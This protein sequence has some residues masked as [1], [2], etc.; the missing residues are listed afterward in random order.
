MSKSRVLPSWPALDLGGAAL[1][2]ELVYERGVW[3]K[4][5][6]ARTDYRW[7]AAS[8]GF[9]P[10]RERLEQRFQLGYEDEPRKCSAWRALAGRHYALSLYPSKATDDDGRSGFLEKQL[11]EWRNDAGLP[12]ALGAL[13]LLPRS[14]TWSDSIWWGRR[15]EPRLAQDPDFVLPIPEDDLPPAPLTTESIENAI[16]A[17]V[18]AWRQAGEQ[19]LADFYA[20]LLAGQ[21]GATL[22]GLDGPPNAQALA[23]LLLPL[24]REVADGLSLAGWLPATAAN[25][26]LAENW[27]GVG[28][29]AERKVAPAGPAPG[30]EHQRRAE[31]LARAL[32][33]NDPRPLAA[34]PRPSALAVPVA[35]AG[36]DSLHISLWGPSSAGKTVL[37]AQLYLFA[38]NDDDDWEIFP[39]EGSLEFIWKMR[40][41]MRESNR[42]PQ[43]TAVGKPATVVYAFKNAQTGAVASMRVEDRAGRTFEELD[44]EAQKTLR[45]AK[46]LVLLVD[47]VLSEAK[48]ESQISKTLEEVHVRSGRGVRKDD[49]P[50]A[51]C[52]SKADLL[53]ETARDAERAHREPDAFVRERVNPVLVKELRRRCDNFK[54]FPVS[55]AGVH[56]RFGVIEPA[57]F[58]DENL[59]PRIG[60]DG[61]PFNLMPPFAWVLDQV[62]GAAA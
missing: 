11:L 47:P 43:A 24:P 36:E 20:S 29:A 53:I 12:A 51:V 45:E 1:P 58:F 50:I 49:R 25:E 4:V 18:A 38:G 5:H 7:I 32:L 17:G 54:L 21:R 52:V 44:E 56:R 10:R 37:L 39:A 62:M 60:R 26:A 48:L 33:E 35:A 23:A 46:G 27:N 9:T 61:V 57:V 59:K 6:G 42:F 30:G 2:G 8:A 19:A 16:D 28:G 15:G 31:R 14:A 34:A 40:E 13:L 3:G 41:V 55:A 22:P